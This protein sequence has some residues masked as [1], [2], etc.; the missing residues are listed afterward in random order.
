MSF[1]FDG[2]YFDEPA[3]S[4]QY[5]PELLKALSQE[6]R[7]IVP[8]ERFLAPYKPLLH[9]VQQAVSSYTAG[10]AEAHSKLLDLQDQLMEAISDNAPPYLLLSLNSTG[11]WCWQIDEWGLDISE[12][13]RISDLSELEDDYRGE[14]VVINDHGNV[15]L[16]H[17]GD[18]GL[19]EIWAAV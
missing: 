2:F 9:T 11:K 18:D 6:L 16:Y 19:R 5:L 17:A 3:D 10:D 8:D 4:E 1:S 12:A 7:R 15:T 14:V 13:L